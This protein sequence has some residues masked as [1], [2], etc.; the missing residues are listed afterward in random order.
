MQAVPRAPGLPGIVMVGLVIIGLVA[1]YFL[2][3]W[4]YGTKNLQ[5]TSLISG[6]IPANVP[7]TKVEAPP[8]IYEGGELS[9]SFWVYVANWKAG[10]GKR[11]HILE[12]GGS[13]FST[14]LIGLG[15]FKNTLFVRTH[16]RGVGAMG[17]GTTI[18][19]AAP[20]TTT[21]LATVAPT[22][23]TT[24]TAPA[25]ATTTPTVSPFQNMPTQDP[26]LLATEVT[27][28]FQP[29]TMDDSVAGGIANQPMCDLPEIDLQRWVL[30]SVVMSGRTV[31]VYLDG[32]LQR[33]CMLPSYF[34]VDTASPLVAKVLQF[35]GFDGYLSRVNAYNYALNPDQVY[36]LYMAGP[37][38]T[39]SDIG[40]WFNSL[41]QS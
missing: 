4:L 8:K 6:Q 31:D 12:I 21:N 30:V 15:A 25:P 3:Q 5:A 34:K 23:T 41:F 39:N 9:V 19:G 20:T 33:S 36:R 40:S 11:K 1:V 29:M 10:L 28:M 2:S 32:K 35:N 14:L 38:G 7:P 13:N 17:S 27:A 22:A 26:T 18:I 37:S 16:T 24:T